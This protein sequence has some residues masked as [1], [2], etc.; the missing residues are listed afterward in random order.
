MVYGPGIFFAKLSLFLLYLRLF[1]PNLWTRA[2]IYF[3]IAST[4]AVYVAT[5]VA[6][7][8]LCI[9]RSGETWLEADFSPRC[10]SSLVMSYVQGIFNVVSDFY[11]LI[12]PIPVVWNL[13][14]PMR[15]KIGV[16]TIFTTGFL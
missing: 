11:L 13:Q 12:L 14:M 3:G 5:T 9:P 15:K 8:A 10:R 7:G 1:K 2:C 6:F 4:F 16:L